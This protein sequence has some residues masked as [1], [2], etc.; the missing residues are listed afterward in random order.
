[1]RS[2]QTFLAFSRVVVVRVTTCL[3]VQSSTCCVW[4]LCPFAGT[5]PFTSICMGFGCGQFQGLVST[6]SSSTGR[7]QAFIVTLCAS[8]MCLS[9]NAMNFVSRLFRRH[10]LLLYKRLLSA[11]GGH[12]YHGVLMM[13][14]WCLP[15]NVSKP[16][17][18]GLQKQILVPAQY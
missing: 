5:N 15:R 1:M 17:F 9:T 13:A 12:N 3:F 10:G 4:I 8:V 18:S 2:V 11:R 7:A 16:Q 14:W 6:Y